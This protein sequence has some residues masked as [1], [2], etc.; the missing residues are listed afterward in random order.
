MNFVYYFT[1]QYQYQF[2]QMGT[3][4]I[5]SGYVNVF[6][7]FVYYCTGQYQYQFTQLGTFCVWSGY[8]DVFMICIILQ[9]STS[10]SL[11]KW[12][13]SVFGVAMLMFS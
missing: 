12:E 8:V 13:L 9:D 10:I 1:G 6:I 2:T 3:F 11:L 5:W 7:N 4:Y